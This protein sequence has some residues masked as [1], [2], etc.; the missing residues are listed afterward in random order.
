M[1]KK[2]KIL[3][4]EARE[5]LDQLKAKISGAKNPDEAKFE[6]AEEAGIPLEKGYNGN[7]TAQQAGKIGGNI[8]GS[9]VRELIKMAEQ[10]L[11]NKQK[12]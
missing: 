4:P 5:G 1:A 8:G 9:M 11:V 10:S 6:I 2:N 7:L 3:V 12:E